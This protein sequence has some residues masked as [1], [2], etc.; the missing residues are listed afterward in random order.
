MFALLQ[1]CDSLFPIGAFS[2]SDGLEAATDAGQ[3][4]DAAALDQWIDACLCEPLAKC[5]GPAVARSWRLAAASEWSDLAALDA[6]VHAL[7]PSSTGR[8]ASRAT[9]SRL[10]RTWQQIRPSAALAEAIV[11]T[12]A[13]LTLPVAFGAVCA[14]SGIDERAAVEGYFYTR[15]ASTI[16]SAMRLM[17]IGQHEAHTL[18]SGALARSPRLVDEALRTSEGPSMFAPALDIAAMS[19][20][21]VVSRLFRS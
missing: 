20:Q 19:Q 7:R 14:S 3:V 13:E 16:S 9:G 4:K 5:D 21:Y 1:L 6:E 10:A 15:L 17:P 2:H 18:L 8:Q 11:H 12:R